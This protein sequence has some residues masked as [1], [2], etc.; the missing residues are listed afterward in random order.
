MSPCHTY[1][2]L[3]IVFG[4]ILSHLIRDYA[5]RAN[6]SGF[7]IFF[8]LKVEFS[9]SPPVQ[10]LYPYGPLPN[11]IVNENAVCNETVAWNGL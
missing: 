5:A 1:H 2:L 6:A 7:F 9:I 10:S 8:Q 11:S 3:N 4:S